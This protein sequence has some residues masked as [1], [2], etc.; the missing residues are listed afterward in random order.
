MIPVQDIL[1]RHPG[2]AAQPREPGSMLP[3]ARWTPDLASLVR[4]DEGKGSGLI[5]WR[6]STSLRA[7]SGLPKLPDIE[8]ALCSADAS[9]P[10][11]I[12]RLR[13]ILLDEIQGSLAGANIPPP[14]RHPPAR[15]RTRR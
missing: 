12:A 4:G 10:P 14:P 3:G 1:S 15:A 7:A 11:A 9:S 2:Q 8:L 6:R 13:E 5:C